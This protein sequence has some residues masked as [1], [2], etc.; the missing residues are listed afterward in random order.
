VLIMLTTE[1]RDMLHLKVL[2]ESHNLS[3]VN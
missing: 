1:T 2:L 3:T